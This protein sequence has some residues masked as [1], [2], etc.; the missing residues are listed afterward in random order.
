MIGRK[1]GDDLFWVV[2][3]LIEQ[4]DELERLRYRVRIAE[5]RQRASKRRSF[6]KGSRAR[7]EAAYG[8]RLRNLPQTR[9]HPKSDPPIAAEP[10][11]GCS[12]TRCRRLLSAV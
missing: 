9:A 7:A 2:R 10:Y 5:A 4:R 1:S 6:L 12:I 3:G 11:G 8:A